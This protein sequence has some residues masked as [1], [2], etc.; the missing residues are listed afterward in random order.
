MNGFIHNITPVITKFGPFY[1]W[2]YGACFCLGF[3]E[4]WFW[5][6]KNRQKLGFQ[7]KEVYLL[8][9]F[10]MVGVILGGRLVEVF[11]YEWSYYRNHLFHIPWLWL[12][13][14][15]TH[16]ILTGSILFV[17]LFAWCYHYSFLKLADV[18]IIAGCF[19]MGMGR[20]GNFIDGQ[21]AG[22]VTDAFF[23]VKFP[24][25]EGYRH[26]VVLY[27]GI[28]NFLLI[29]CLLWIR[30]RKPAVGVVFAHFILWYGLLRFPIDFFREYRSSFYGF[31]PGQEFNLFMAV[32]GLALILY[33]R[34]KNFSVNK[35]PKSSK[36][37]LRVCR[38]CFFILLPLPLII[39]SDWTYD[40]PQKYGKR[41]PNMEN[42]VIYPKIEKEKLE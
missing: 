42:S 11:F 20:I 30:S 25:L 36:L 7:I 6:R 35:K 1:L 29:P 37:S 12:G 2:W 32:L 19:I 38:L 33:F 5:T 24:E 40:I 9:I 3:L 13:G 18:L 27:D 10:V 23:G 4:V 21:I 8:C 14:M 17:M 26:P 15:S 22:T 39:P 41:Y 16:G 34:H 28:K 31:P